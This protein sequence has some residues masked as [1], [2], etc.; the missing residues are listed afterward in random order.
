[1][2]SRST[3]SSVSVVMRAEDGVRTPDDRGLVLEPLI[4]F[5]SFS[6]S[7]PFE[8]AFAALSFC[9]LIYF[10]K[11]SMSAVVARVDA[12]IVLKALVLM[13]GIAVI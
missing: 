4:G 9:F 5:V 3:V 8:L 1:V 2:L 12:V 7:W 13:V 10:L 6:A 11:P